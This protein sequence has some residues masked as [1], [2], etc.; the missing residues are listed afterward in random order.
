MR[1]NWEEAVRRVEGR[2][3]A[4]QQS[5]ALITI[6][7]AKG[8]EWPIVIPIN[9]TGTPKSEAEIMHDR[10]AAQ[11]SIPVLGVEPPAY[12]AL[13]ALNELEQARE[14]VRLWY[15]ATTRA[16]DLLVLTRHASKLPDKSWAQ[17][18][19]LDLASLPALNPDQLGD[20]KPRTADAAEN[21]QTRAIFAGE[22]ERI[23]KAEIKFTWQRPSRGEVE[24][25]EVPATLPI[26]TDP[27]TVDKA[28]EID[29]SDVAGGV[30]RGTILHKLMEE[31]LTGETPDDG[32]V[33]V[34]RAT[35]LLTQL[36]VVPS[37]DPKLAIAATELAETITRTLGFAEIVALRP[38]VSRPED[39]HP[40]PLAERC[41][42][43]SIH[44][45]PIR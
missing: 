12:S 21:S 34:Q 37:A 36:G 23:A 5:V 18:V 10:R 43:L 25:I 26:F 41:V 33:I 20:A 39:F 45:A 30:T 29:R 15:V 19:D 44:T 27:E 22:A 38:R 35:D 6:H 13:Q 1:A 4:E 31:V 16:R 8:L 32:T 40:R 3:D 7:A 24:K 9:M 42:N 28:N 14:R 2:P 17:T 11:F